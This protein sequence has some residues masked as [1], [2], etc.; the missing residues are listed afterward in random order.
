M[1]CQS[2]L[3]WNCS[4]ITVKYSK[5]RHLSVVPLSIVRQL[6][7]C[8]TEVYAL[9][10]SSAASVPVWA[11]A[12]DDVNFPCR[13]DADRS[14]CPYVGYDG[15]GCWWESRTHSYE[16]SAAST[17]TP[18]H[19]AYCPCPP[20]QFYFFIFSSWDLDRF[21]P[22]VS[23]LPI[24]ILRNTSADCTSH[25]KKLQDMLRLGLPHAPICASQN[26]KTWRNI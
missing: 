4:E 19:D 18:S 25:S 6:L 21:S 22:G 5:I 8:C 15:C 2:Q 14:T 16:A 11:R 24:K 10:H 17:Y 23:S 1:L 26:Q 20:F 7:E 3:F 13:W 9:I 12:G